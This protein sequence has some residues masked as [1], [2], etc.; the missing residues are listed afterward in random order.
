[1]NIVHK[2]YVIDL[3]KRTYLE[4]SLNSQHP[5]G[6]GGNCKWPSSSF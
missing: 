6:V 2:K 5:F 3:Q 4:I 1:M